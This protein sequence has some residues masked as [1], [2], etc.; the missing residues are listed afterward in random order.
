MSKILKKLKKQI[1]T[2]GIQKM[3]CI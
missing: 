3:L 2:H 1:L